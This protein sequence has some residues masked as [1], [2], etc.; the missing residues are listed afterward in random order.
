[1][2]RFV[3]QVDDGHGGISSVEIVVQVRPRNDPPVNTAR[4]SILGNRKVGQVLAVDPGQ[5]NDDLDNMPAPTQFAYQ[6]LKGDSPDGRNAYEIAHATGKTYTVR[7]EDQDKFLAVRVTA[8]SSGGGAPAVAS[9]DATTPF[10]KVGNHAP[11]ISVAPP[12]IKIV[13]Q[14]FRFSGNTGVPTEDLQAVVAEFVGQSFTLKQL[15][16]IVDRITEAYRRRDMVLARAYLPPQEV[17]DGI[18]QIAIQEGRVGRIRVQGNKHYKDELVR[19]HINQTVQTPNP[20]GKQLEAG[21]RTMNARYK[22]LHVTSVLS[23]GE[24]PGTVDVNALVREDRPI[25]GYLRYNNFG[26]DFVNE[27][28]FIAGFDWTNALLSGDQ[29]SVQGLI[30]PDP[31]DLAFV[32]GRYTFP[33]NDRST[34]LGVMGSGGSYKVSKEFEDLGLEGESWSAGVFI[35]HPFIIRRDLHV[36]G[37]F[38]FQAKESKF[39]ILDQVSSDDDIRLVYGTLRVDWDHLGGTTHAAANITQGLGSFLGGL[40]E[41]DPMASRKEADNSFTRFLL[42]ASRLQPLNSDWSL[43]GSVSGQ[44]ATDSLVASEEWQVGGF[45]SVRG[46]APGEGTGDNGYNVRLEARYQPTLPSF[47]SSSPFTSLLFVDHGYVHRHNPA[48]GEDED[49]F[50]TGAGLGFR[51]GHVWNGMAANLILD[52]GWPLSPSSNTRSDTPFIYLSTD[53]QF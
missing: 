42:S 51:L 27:H 6:W 30:G 35:D 17:K 13:A 28:R 10:Y 14:G 32:S 9:A 49:D 43:F 33:I 53:M 8:M 3:I 18:I 39:F 23:P 34:K 46:F 15:N 26:S 24:E 37:E 47:L 2:D 50:F 44:Y 45:H 41:D 21:L 7:A 31:G 11:T 22:G 19:G 40:S 20:T 48:V 52:I 5:W 38:G 29:L 36:T 4:P 1:M 25:T 16:G 12:P